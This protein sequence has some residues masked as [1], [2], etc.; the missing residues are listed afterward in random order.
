MLTR[1]E[2]YTE[3][4]EALIDELQEQHNWTHT[5]EVEGRHFH[6]FKTGHR[7]GSYYVVGFHNQNSSDPRDRQAFTEVGLWS[8]NREKNKAIFDT[9][10]ERKFEMKPG[11]VCNSNGIAATNGCAVANSN[12]PPLVYGVRETLTPM[13]AP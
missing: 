6:Q 2:R 10:E 13:N 3:Y 1:G 9:L 5:R 8:D 11:S 12:D 4:F 7:I